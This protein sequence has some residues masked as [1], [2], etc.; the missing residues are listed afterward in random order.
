VVAGSVELEITVSADVVRAKVA[1]IEPNL[2]V[3]IGDD[4]VVRVR[5]ARQPGWGHLEVEPVLDAEQG[6]VLAPQ[7]LQVAGMRF[8]AVRRMRPTVVEVPD[9]PRGLRLTAVEPGPGELVL[10]GEAERWRERIPLTDLLG[11]LATAAST[12]TLPRFPG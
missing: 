10:R 2:V 11:W 8:G 6:L 5:W 4:S 9:L 3:D 1:E 12:L 7:V